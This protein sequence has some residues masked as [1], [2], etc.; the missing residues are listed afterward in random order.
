M[1]LDGGK[2]RMRENTDRDYSE[3]AEFCSTE[4]LA[5]SMWAEVF[6][7]IC[8]TVTPSSISGQAARD[9]METALQGMAVP[10]TGLAVLVAAANGF[11]TTLMGGMAPYT[12]V[13]YPAF[14]PADFG[15]PSLAAPGVTAETAAGVMAGKIVARLATGVV[16]LSVPPFTVLTLL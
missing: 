11:A 8:D 10:A 9:A 5:A 13:S 12:P 2:N 1:D 14:V 4:A 15:D 6:K 3:F 7:A 16:Q